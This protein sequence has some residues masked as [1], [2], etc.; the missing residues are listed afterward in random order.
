MSIISLGGHLCRTSDVQ[1][2]QIKVLVEILNSIHLEDIIFFV[3]E[4]E[5]GVGVVGSRGAIAAMEDVAVVSSG[6]G[7]RFWWELPRHGRW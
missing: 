5:R 2:S 7:G 6:G 1:T 3:G 4:V